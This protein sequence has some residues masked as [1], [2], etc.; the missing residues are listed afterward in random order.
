V[1][2]LENPFAQARQRCSAMP[3]PL[4]CE[5]R[6]GRTTSAAPSNVALDFS[7]AHEVPLL[8]DPALQRALAR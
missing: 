2:L 4:T 1:R 6:H 5:C 8:D 3:W 7:E